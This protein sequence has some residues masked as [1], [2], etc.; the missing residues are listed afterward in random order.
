[1]PSFPSVKSF[2][3]GRINGADIPNASTVF[4]ANLKKTAY[5]VF[6]MALSELPLYQR[7]NEGDFAHSLFFFK[8]GF[9]EIK[10]K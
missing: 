6:F 5:A 9:S 4:P 8:K 1:M 10:E 3:T 7:G 2:A